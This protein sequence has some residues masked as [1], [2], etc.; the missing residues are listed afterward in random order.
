MT[1]LRQQVPKLSLQFAG[2][3]P[4]L[5]QLKIQLNRPPAKPS[6]EE[7]SAIVKDLEARLLNLIPVAE[8]EDSE[9][10]WICTALERFSV[11]P[12]RIEKYEDA[13]PGYLQDYPKYLDQDHESR[14]MFARTIRLDIVLVNTGSAPAEDSIVLLHLPDK[15]VLTERK[16]LPN[17]IPV[18]PNF[19]RNSVEEE[20]ETV[21]P[22]ST[23]RLA[24][25]YRGRNID[26]AT[27]NVS[28][29]TITK[30]DRYHVRVAVMTIKPSREILLD[31]LW[32]IFPD[33]DSASSFDFTYSILAGNSQKPFGGA[34]NVIV[35]KA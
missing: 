22:R 8:S 28:T 6:A 29:P 13:I 12:A 32:V 27:S 34:L 9:D 10:N 35:E 7:V 33:F 26:S 3:H 30:V 19:P 2:N 14:T 25:N 11:S 1:L 18:A 15:F 16:P 21:P 4:N 5:D 20:W 23:I 17:K 31:P 24:G